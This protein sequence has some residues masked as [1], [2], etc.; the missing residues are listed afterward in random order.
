MQLFELDCIAVKGKKDGVRIYTVLEKNLNES[1]Y[2]IVV[3]GHFAFLNDYRMQTWDTAISHANE[4]IK[5]NKELKKYYE[6]MIERILELRS[7]NLDKD[8]DGVF[9]A[10]SK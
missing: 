10:T 3:S 9:R 5:Q 8:W 7:S 4:L 6:M 1:Q 2:N